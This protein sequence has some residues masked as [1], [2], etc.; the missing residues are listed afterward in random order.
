MRLALFVSISIALGSPF[1]TAE[2]QSQEIEEIV[3]VGVPIKINRERSSDLVMHTENIELSRQVDYSD[4]DLTEHA[5][6]ME[7][8]A[9]VKSMAERSCKKLETIFPL[10]PADIPRCVDKAVANAESNI[11]AAIGNSSQ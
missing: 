2:A 1:A 10:P 4:L 3:V 8:R 6:V 5:D 7:L 9:R 11:Q